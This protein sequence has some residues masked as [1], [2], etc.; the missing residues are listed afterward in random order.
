MADKPL[1][2]LATGENAPE[3]DA[4][5]TAFAAMVGAAKGCFS[6]IAYTARSFSDHSGRVG[7]A[8]IRARFA[9]DPRLTAVETLIAIFGQQWPQVSSAPLPEIHEDPLAPP[10]PASPELP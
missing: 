8:A 6:N 2:V 4:V 1:D 9:G 7:M 10:E 5:E 3:P